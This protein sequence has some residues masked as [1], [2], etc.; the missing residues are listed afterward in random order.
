MTFKQ[1]LYKVLI[2]RGGYL[3]SAFLLNILFVRNYGAAGSSTIYYLIN[4]YSFVLLVTGLS[5]ESGMGFFLAKKEADTGSVAFLSIGWTLM[6][7]LLSFFLL[8]VWFLFFDPE[9]QKRLWVMSALTFIPGQLLITFYTALFY[10]KESAALPNMVLTIINILLIFLL[11]S[12]RLSSIGSGAYLT[13]YF[14]GILVQGVVLAT[15]FS[16]KFRKDSPHMPDR[17]LLRRIF[18]YSL[19]ALTANI[20]FFL[21]YRV[22]YWFVKRYCTPDELGNYIQVSKL[23]QMILVL[24]GVLAS[25]VFPGTALGK[26]V[27]MPAHLGRMSRIAVLLFAGLFIGV[28]LIGRPL[29]PLIFG[30]GFN[31][32]YI[33][34]LV[35]L[36]GIFFLSVLLLLSAW[37]GGIHRP[38]VNAGSALAG[39]L[40]I[41]VGDWLLIPRYRITAAAAVSTAGYFTCLLWSL[42]AFRKECRIGLGSLW[43]IKKEDWRWLKR[44]AKNIAK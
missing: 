3:L 30:S 16:I 27:D 11:P 6:A 39:L 22:D 18:R 23:G 13:F 5:L 19:I 25:A 8:N 7:S 10:S 15:F 38:G 24:P 40:I 41:I 12:T 35:M 28:L 17:D 34:F 31:K 36:P 43:I 26:D 4:L 2:W 32:M 14:T 21:V 33:P 29:F 42:L 20:A 44:Q 1:L 9:L 37:F